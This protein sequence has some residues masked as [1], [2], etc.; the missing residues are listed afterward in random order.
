M[1]LTE[2]SVAGADRGRDN[3]GALDRGL[4]ILEYL[5]E[6]REASTA[7]IAQHVRLTR[8][9]AYRLLDRLQQRGFVDQRAPGV[10]VPGAAAARLAMAAVQSADVVQVAPEFLR[11]LVQQAR[12]TVGLAV[13]SGDEMVFVY[14]ERGPHFVSVSSELGARRPLHC[15]SVG[16]AYLAALPMSERVPLIRRLELT[17]FTPST[18]TDRNALELEVHHTR[19]RGWSE[20]RGEFNEDSTCCGA[21]ILNH[22]GHPVAAIS[23]AGPTL[24]TAPQLH[25]LGGLVASTADAISRRLGYNNDV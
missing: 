22:A 21:A 20:D 23:A 14:R 9:T 24:R 2:R 4:D 11:M 15:T 3:R 6:T 5:S 13:P 16:K 12:E 7:M 18:I 8:S 25:R 10:W 1:T 17:R 19:E